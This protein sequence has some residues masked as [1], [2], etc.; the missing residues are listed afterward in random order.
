MN[1]LQNKDNLFKLAWL[2]N[3]NKYDTSSNVS[4]CWCEWTSDQCECNKIRHQAHLFNVFVVMLSS[5]ILEKTFILQMME[6][7]NRN[8]VLTGSSD[9]VVRVCLTHL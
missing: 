3:S 1:S 8:V 9:G 4:L 7:D 5:L 6:W 2:K